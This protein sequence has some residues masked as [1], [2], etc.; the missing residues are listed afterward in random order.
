MIDPNVQSFFLIILCGFACVWTYRK[1]SGN[2]NSK[3]SDFEYLAFSAISGSIIFRD[4]LK[5]S[6]DDSDLLFGFSHYPFLSTPALVAI[7]AVVGT[8]V[9]WAAR[10]AK[11][12]YTKFTRLFA[13]HVHN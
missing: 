9:A 4:V 1:V 6:L 3:I 12:C 8:V 5:N 2:S 11:F 13:G 10:L 7:G